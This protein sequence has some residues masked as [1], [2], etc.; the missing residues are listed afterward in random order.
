MI[1]LSI[2][3]GNEES[4]YC[5]YSIKTNSLDVDLSETHKILEFGKIKNEDLIKYVREE[6]F[7]GNYIGYD[8]IV[9]EGIISY[10]MPIGKT[11]LHT[12]FFVGRLF[13]LALSKVEEN[14]IFIISRKEVLLHHCGSVRAKDSNLRQA[15][16]DKFGE[17]GTKK[18]PGFTYG[19]SKDVWSAFGIATYFA[20]NKVKGNPILDIIK[21]ERR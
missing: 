7:E 10:G 11:T 14:N 3:P 19:I 8:Y 4:A 2:D 9:I 13:Q 1:I 15:L 18:S 17:P 21:D 20:E 12:K 6:T 5:L 16:I